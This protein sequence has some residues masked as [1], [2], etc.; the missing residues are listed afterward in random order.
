[1]KRF[2]FN[3]AGAWLACCIGFLPSLWAGD[4]RLGSAGLRSGFS[5]TDATDGV[6][7][8]EVFGQFD[9]PWVREWGSGWRLET[10]L[11]TAVGW[12]DDGDAGTAFGRIGPALTLSKAQFPVSLAGGLSPTFL[13]RDQFGGTDLGSSVQFSTHIGLN[14]DLGGRWRI[15]YRFQHVSNAGLG[16]PNPGLDLQM[17]SVSFR[18]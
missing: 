5:T 14:A 12:L 3:R 10:W 9:L 7:Q 18:F 2:C 8:Y 11:D 1:M 6:W 4:F 13:G 15:G 17:F 16:S